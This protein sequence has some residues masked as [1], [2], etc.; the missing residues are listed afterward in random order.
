MKAVNFFEDLPEEGAVEVVEEIAEFAQGAVRIERIISGGQASNENFWYEQEE[1]EWVMLVR[2]QA[3]LMIEGQEEALE[4]K[5]GDHIELPA[6][7]RHRVE[8]VSQDALWLA[9]W[10]NERRI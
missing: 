9:V 8:S 3:R 4:M 2:G 10:V 6:K 5:A 7:L 1:H